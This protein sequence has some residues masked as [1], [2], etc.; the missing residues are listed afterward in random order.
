[1]KELSSLSNLFEESIRERRYL[2]SGNAQAPDYNQLS[3]NPDT[4]A[5]FNL[6][7]A[8]FGARA[9]CVVESDE[10]ILHSVAF[11]GDGRYLAMGAR[12]K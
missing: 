2:R 6:L 7:T 9:Q 3:G 12:M 5:A 4:Q 8:T 10:V 11:S 1:M